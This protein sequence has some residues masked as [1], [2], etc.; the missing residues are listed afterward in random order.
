MVSSVIG[1]YGTTT[2]VPPSTPSTT[3]TAGAAANAYGQSASA[4]TNPAA[5]VNVTLSAEA[6]AALAAQKDA[7]TIDAVIGA[8]R[9]ALDKLLSDAKAT[10]ALKDGKATIDVSGLDRRTLYAIASNQGGKFSIEEQVVASLQMKA[11]RDAALA[12]P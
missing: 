2:Y 5:S 3:S 8:A 1:G 10:T 6:Q 9:S 11:T 12:A 4:A 7:R